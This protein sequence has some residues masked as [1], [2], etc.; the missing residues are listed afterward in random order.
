VKGV[1]NILFWSEDPPGLVAAHFS[2]ILFSTLALEQQ[3]T[4]LEA[5]ALT[6]FATQVWLQMCSRGGV[7]GEDPEDMCTCEGESHVKHRRA[8]LGPSS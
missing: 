3:V 4:L 1:P 2:S 7:G 6:L 5:Y 8:H